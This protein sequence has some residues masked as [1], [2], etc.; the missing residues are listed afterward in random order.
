M[1]MVQDEQGNGNVFQG[2][3]EVTPI[4]EPLL[5]PQAEAEKWK[6]DE[7]N[8]LDRLDPAPPPKAS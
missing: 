2:E 3:T 4:G 6:P 7:T 1:S 5:L 8:W